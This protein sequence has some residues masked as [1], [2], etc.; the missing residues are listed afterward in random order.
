VTATP[1]DAPQPE[2]DDGPR[3]ACGVFG[4]Y[5]PQEPAAKLAYY[6]LYALQHRGQ[7]SAGIAVSD[8]TAILVTKEMGLVDQVFDEARLTALEGH[9]GIGHVRYST[10]GSS[11]W[12]NA[13]PTFRSTP[14]GNVVCL[15]HN[16]NLTN[17]GALT[18]R[19]P[20]G[21]K[22]TSDSDVL[23]AL[24]A[25]ARDRDP[26]GS[27]EAALAEVLPQA[28]GAFSLV[29]MDERTIYGARDPW[30]VRPL[31][32]GRLKS[33]GWVVASETAAL[34]IVGAKRVRDVE[35]GEIVA[36]DEAGL[37]SRRF[38]DASPKA[39][40]FEYVYVA[41][42]DHQTAETTVYAA[43]R[44]MGELLAREAPVVADLVIPVPDSGAAAAGGFSAASG[45]PYA[46][47]LT[48]NRYV[49]RTFIQPTQSLRQ[50]GIRLKLNPLPD[51]I[52]GQRLVV[53][54]DSIVRGNTSRQLVAMLRDA[55]AAEVHLRIT[56][57]PVR[58]PCFYGIDMATR[59][60]LLAA[61]MQTEEIRAFLDADS[62]A[63]LSLGGLVE[64]T[65]RP[66]SSL[67]A[68]C[69]DGTYPIPVESLQQRHGKAVM[70][71]L[72]EER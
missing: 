2:T 27:M 59:A 23:S 1:A 26:S 72:W 36:I 3:D 60:E 52:A 51:I 42:P 10:T 35:P 47:G 70:A 45:I 41:R 28:D 33:G 21:D 64:T 67:C 14:A 38:A 66:A 7:E 12:D 53:V 24:V 50:L 39:C 46:E 37:R 69:F 5:A 34:D 8:G 56:S 11:T 32:I 6:G 65:R 19:L 18:A 71:T 4:V 44:R 55:G 9:L 15:A 43:R 31:V 16:G 25:D 17:T 61:G 57:P 20:A 58:W 63:Y 40:V 22:C 62:L 48:K 68:A 29:V 54:D 30:G 13:Q 49:G